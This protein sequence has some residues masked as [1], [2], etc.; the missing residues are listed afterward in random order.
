MILVVTKNMKDSST[1]IATAVSFDTVFG[2][3]DG[4]ISAKLGMQKSWYSATLTNNA[5]YK[6]NLAMRI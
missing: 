5:I 1:E 6:S 2:I 3:S 4:A